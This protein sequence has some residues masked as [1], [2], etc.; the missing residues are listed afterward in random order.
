MQAQG[1]AQKVGS[2]SDNSIDA[3]VDEVPHLN[4]L[5]HDPDNKLQPGGAAGLDLRSRHEGGFQGHGICF[6]RARNGRNRD[7]PSD[8]E[9][10]GPDGW[11]DLLYASQ[12]VMVKGC[13]GRMLDRGV[14]A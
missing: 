2:V 3:K 13:N 10:G 9:S 12:R 1:R 8:Q 11:L 5:V 7:G 6:A 4:R 14:A